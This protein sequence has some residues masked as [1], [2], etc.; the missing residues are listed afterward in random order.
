MENAI[1]TSPIPRCAPG[2]VLDHGAAQTWGY[3]REFLLS[4]QFCT[5]VFSEQR[6]QVPSWLWTYSVPSCRYF[7]SYT[8]LDGPKALPDTSNWMCFCCQWPLEIYNC[9]HTLHGSYI[10]ERGGKGQGAVWCWIPRMVLVP[11]MPWETP[12]GRLGGHSKDME[13][14]CEVRAKQLLD[15]EKPAESNFHRAAW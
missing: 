4:A 9:C 5:L 10:P 13:P 7:W 12:E 15:S 11:R 8:T 1:L 6:L 3:H 2:P 14:Q